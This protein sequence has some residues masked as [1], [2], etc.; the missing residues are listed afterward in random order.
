M[1]TFVRDDR[2]YLYQ[3]K[4]FEYMFTAECTPQPPS[5]LALQRMAESI[6][7]LYTTKEGKSWISIVKTRW[8][9]PHAIYERRELPRILKLIQKRMEAMQCLTLTK[10]TEHT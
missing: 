7:E 6:I 3:D 5:L 1:K 10:S 8:T 4:T 9:E 2:I